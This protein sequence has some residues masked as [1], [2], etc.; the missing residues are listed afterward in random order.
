MNGEGREYEIFGSDIRHIR[1]RNR[2]QK[3]YREE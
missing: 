1:V 2:N 3:L